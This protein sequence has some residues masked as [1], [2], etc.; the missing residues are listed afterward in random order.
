MKI[1]FVGSI[2]EPVHRYQLMILYSKS[3]EQR[4]KGIHKRQVISEEEKLEFL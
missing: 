3:N 4:T 1:R 2:K